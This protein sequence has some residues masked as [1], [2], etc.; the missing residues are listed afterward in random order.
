MD[1]GAHEI[2]LDCQSIPVATGHLDDGFKTV[3]CHVNSGGYTTKAHNPGLVIGYVSRI[4]NAPQEL[5]LTV[6]DRSV[7][8]FRWTKFSGN[9]EVTPCQHLLKIAPGF[10]RRHSLCSGIDRHR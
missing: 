9:G 7:H 6:Y 8:V 10:K 4:H 5:D 3:L 1:I 2:T